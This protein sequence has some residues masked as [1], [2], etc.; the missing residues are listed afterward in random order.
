MIKPVLS[1]CIQ[2]DVI[3]EGQV[4][5]FLDQFGTELPVRV[6]LIFRFLYL[7]LPSWQHI[8]IF[9]FLSL[10]S[11]NNLS[12]PVWL[13]KSWSSFTMME[14]WCLGHLF[15]SSH[16]I[17]KFPGS[18]LIFGHEQWDKPTS[19]FQYGTRRMEVVQLAIVPLELI[20]NSLILMLSRSRPACNFNFHVL[21]ISITTT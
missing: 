13:E 10:P 2:G 20:G 16:L 17:V 3:K 18:C 9:S 19:S 15:F 8:M 7:W 14:V 6:S 11:W 12:S 5:G 1:L 4:I 21:L